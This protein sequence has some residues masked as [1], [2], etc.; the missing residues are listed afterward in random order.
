VF[1]APLS[2]TIGYAGLD[3]ADDQASQLSLQ[4]W[5]GEADRWVAIP[6]TVDAAAQTVTARIDRPMTLALV[7][8]EAAPNEEE[9]ATRVYLPA[10][11]R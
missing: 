8:A 1:T 3:I 9:D 7:V 4:M 10:V 6:F 2:L 11:Q 5:D